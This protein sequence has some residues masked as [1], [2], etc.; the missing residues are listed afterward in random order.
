MDRH[1]KCEISSAKHPISLMDGPRSETMTA[2]RGLVI[3]GI[4]LLALSS[5]CVR[6]VRGDMHA[7]TRTAIDVSVLEVVGGRSRMFRAVEGDDEVRSVRR[8]T[9]N[10]LSAKKLFILFSRLSVGWFWGGACISKISN[11]ETPLSSVHGRCIVKA[12]MRR[13]ERGSHREKVEI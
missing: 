13:A 4:L 9:Y 12:A 1:L 10:S 2:V 3:I 7:H 11:L 6:R 5:S 8:H